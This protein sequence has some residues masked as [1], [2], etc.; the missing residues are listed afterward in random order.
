MNNYTNNIELKEKITFGQVWNNQPP[1]MN[2]CF[3]FTTIS[4]SVV[5]MF[6]CTML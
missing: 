4:F 1:V 2:W 3:A 6:L 5:Y